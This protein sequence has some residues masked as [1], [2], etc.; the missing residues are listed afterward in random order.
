[1]V[2]EYQVETSD[3]QLQWRLLVDHCRST[4]VVVS[5]A[6][7]PDSPR[8][9]VRAV[10]KH[11]S[12]APGLEVTAPGFSADEEPEETPS[13]EVEQEERDG[14]WCRWRCRRRKG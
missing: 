10:N 1:M 9:R 4:S 8:F 13:A 2:T 14:E 7:L 11:G 12:S 3:D 6:E 5:A